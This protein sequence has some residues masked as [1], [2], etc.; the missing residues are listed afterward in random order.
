MNRNLTTAA[1]KTQI[2]ASLLVALG[3][4]GIPQVYRFGYNGQIRRWKLPAAFHIE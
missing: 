3:C 2:A 1:R 4:T